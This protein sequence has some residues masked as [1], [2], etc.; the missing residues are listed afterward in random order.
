MTLQHGMLHARQ[1]GMSRNKLLTLSHAV[2]V[3]KAVSRDPLRSEGSATILA[4]AD[5]FVREY[6]SG[7]L[8]SR[9]AETEKAFKAHRRGERVLAFY[10]RAS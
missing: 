5:Q 10:V 4:G 3:A 8:Y 7:E 9:A 1:D 2:A 6:R